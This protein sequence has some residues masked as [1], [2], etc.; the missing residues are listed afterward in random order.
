[1]DRGRPLRQQIGFFLAVRCAAERFQVLEALGHVGIVRSYGM[2]V[3]SVPSATSCS[4]IQVDA[5]NR[6]EGDHVYLSFVM[7][8]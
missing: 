8:W 1:M 4:N 5:E 6:L 3:N 7:D 2:T